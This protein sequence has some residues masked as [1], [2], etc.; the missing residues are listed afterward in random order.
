M[1]FAKSLPRFCAHRGEERGRVAQRLH[2]VIR[3][4]SSVMTENI[5]QSDIGAAFSINPAAEVRLTT[6][7]L[8]S[9][10]NFK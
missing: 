9:K 8:V 1:P 10:M 5:G 3:Q 2:K 7:C 6:S 4:I